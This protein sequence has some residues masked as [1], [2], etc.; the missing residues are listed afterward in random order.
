MYSHLQAIIPTITEKWHNL[1]R[2]KHMHQNKIYNPKYT[3]AFKQYLKY[4]TPVSEPYYLG[5]EVEQNQAIA[6]MP[7]PEAYDPKYAKKVEEYINAKYLE[8]MDC[9]NNFNPNQPRVPAGSPE[10]GQWTATGS[11]PAEGQSTSTTPSPKRFNLDGALNK[12]KNQVKPTTNGDCAT[13]VRIALEKGGGLTLIRPKPRADRKV[14]AQDYGASL[15]QAGFKEVHIETYAKYIPQ[16]GDIA[17]IQPY[18]GGNPSGHMQMY[19]GEHWISD[20]VQ[21]GFWAGR[22]TGYERYKPPF[23]IYRYID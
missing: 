7:P 22:G 14:H 13:Y 6:L 15:L 2:G 9:K 23:K 10:G 3:E 18:P 16:K 12:L 4:G 17:I 1:I 21:G 11:S 19:D 5:E 8:Y 20:W